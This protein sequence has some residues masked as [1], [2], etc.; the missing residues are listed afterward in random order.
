M[1]SSRCLRTAL[2]RSRNASSHN[3]VFESKSYQVSRALQS[4]LLQKTATIRAGRALTY[5]HAV[6]AI[7]DAL[8]RTQVAEELK[9]PGGEESL[10][11]L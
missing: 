11:K 10:H 7:P 1:Q 5:A 6:G 4:Q 9:F 3:A 2:L 8:A